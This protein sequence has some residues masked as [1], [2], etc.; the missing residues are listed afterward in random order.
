MLDAVAKT[1]GDKELESRAKSVR[2]AIIDLSYNGKF[3]CENAIRVNGKLKICKDHLSE[4]C[5]YYALFTGICPDDAFKYRMMNE[6]GPSREERI[7]ITVFSR[8]MKQRF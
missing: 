1:Y 2:Q 5:Q 7:Y 3:F 8:T 6:F 4:T